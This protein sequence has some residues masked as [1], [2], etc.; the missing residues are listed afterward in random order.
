MGW[1]DKLSGSEK[2]SSKKSGLPALDLR[3]VKLPTGWMGNESSKESALPNAS[4]IYGIG[5]GGL[6]AVSLYS[7][8]T[9]AW[10]T[11]VLLLLPAGALIGF[12]LHYIRHPS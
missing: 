1:I 6:L 10:F 3:G 2:A 8:L 4:I 12:A 11:G 7:F 9:G 5:S